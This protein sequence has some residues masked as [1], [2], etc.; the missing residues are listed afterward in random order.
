MTT[1]IKYFA[2]K[3]DKITKKYHFTLYSD[4][5]ILITEQEQMDN[6]K[7]IY[8]RID[9][10]QTDEDLAILSVLINES[11]SLKIEKAK[12][13]YADKELIR[14]EKDEL[15]DE[16]KIKIDKDMDYKM[17]VFD[18]L[19][20]VKAKY[21]QTVGTFDITVTDEDDNEIIITHAK[22][23]EAGWAL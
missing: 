7:Q 3:P 9:F 10:G 4:I 19:D 13:H 1:T 16:D 12:K 5:D 20:E 18:S 6:A 8:P 21:P 2:V 23:K 11:A 14:L 22:I 15:S 17:K